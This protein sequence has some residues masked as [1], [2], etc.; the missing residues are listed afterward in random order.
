M[1][2]NIIRLEDTRSTNV[3]LRDLFSNQTVPEVYNSKPNTS[4]QGEARWGIHGKVNKVKSAFSLSCCS[5]IL[6]RRGNSSYFSD[7]QPCDK[8][9]ARPFCS[10]DLVLS[11]PTIFTGINKKS[12]DVDRK[13]HRRN[14]AFSQHSWNRNSILIRRSL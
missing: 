10:L 1:K 2:Y 14:D 8:R 3:Y 4:R 12:V 11:G 7:N 6:F 5:P 13:R 9:I